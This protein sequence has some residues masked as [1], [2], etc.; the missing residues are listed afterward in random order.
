MVPSKG[1]IQLPSLRNTPMDEGFGGIPTALL[2]FAGKYLIDYLLG[3]CN[4]LGIQEVRL[5]DENGSPEVKSFLQGGAPWD[6]RIFYHES[7]YLPSPR[8]LYNRVR[9]FVQNK[10]CLFYQGLQ[11]PTASYSIVV[12]ERFEQENWRDVDAKAPQEGIFLIGPNSCRQCDYPISPIH[13]YQ[14]YFDCNFYIL[15]AARDTFPIPGYLVEKGVHIG[16]NVEMPP[17]V[18][19]EEPAVICNHVRLGPRIRMKGDTIIGSYTLVEEDV[20]MRHSIILDDTYVAPHLD[21]IDKIVSRTAIVDPYTNAV[22]RLEADGLVMDTRRFR[23]GGILAYLQDVAMT[24]CLVLFQWPLYFVFTHFFEMERSK[25]RFQG[26]SGRRRSF[27]K[28]DLSSTKILDLYFYKFALDR[29]PL[30]KFVFTKEMRLFGDS[31][32]RPPAAGEL[33]RPGVY[34]YSDCAE[35]PRDTYSLERNDHYAHRHAGFLFTLKNL[36]NIF[37]TRILATSVDLLK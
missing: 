37:I 28:Y 12:P 24:L 5:L 9:D 18:E 29:F 32:R 2:P 26:M 8:S 36:K 33:Y 6:V 14:D 3:L 22:L 4:Q 16:M 15:H 20:S 1:V 31:F 34:C 25:L 35:G 30:Y 10:E 19:C 13:T 21:L 7:L 23:W 17:S 27:R 11:F